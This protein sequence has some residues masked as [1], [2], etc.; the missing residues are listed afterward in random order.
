MPGTLDPASSPAKREAVVARGVGRDTKFREMTSD[1]CGR[2]GISNAHFPRE[3][4]ISGFE[5]QVS[6]SGFKMSKDFTGLEIMSER[7]RDRPEVSRDD[8]RFVGEHWHLQRPFASGPQRFI[9]SC[10][11]V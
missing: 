2:T 7:E 6:D 5:F 4:R 8:E 1:S 11:G 9:L 3:L 10:R